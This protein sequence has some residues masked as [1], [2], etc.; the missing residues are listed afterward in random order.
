[1]KAAVI[2]MAFC[3][4]APAQEAIAAEEIT[5]SAVMNARFLL[6]PPGRLHNQTLRWIQRNDRQEMIG[7][8]LHVMR[9]SEPDGREWCP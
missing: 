5:D 7:A 8:L 6:Y 9:F 3:L 1:M 4:G 2:V